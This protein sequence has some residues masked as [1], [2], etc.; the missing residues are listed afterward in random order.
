MRQDGQS[1]TIELNAF[2]SEIFDAHRALLA[3]ADPAESLTRVFEKVGRA[4]SVDR[5]Y[6]FENH[7]DEAGTVYS[8][9]RFEWAAAGVT[10]Q[11]DNPGLQ[12]I[13][14]RAAGYSR[15]LDNFLSYRPIHG[16]IDSFPESERARL[17]EQSIESLLILPVFTG[18]DLWGFVGFDDCT[19]ER[20]WTEA[21]LDLLFALT[22]TLGQLFSGQQSSDADN[23]TIAA[24][25]LVG[26][27]L[28][29]D[30]ALLSETPV[31][32]LVN[33]TRARLSVTVAVHRF[34]A[35]EHTTGEVDAGR[36][37]TALRGRLAAIRQCDDEEA[38]VCRTDVSAESF[39][40]GVEAALDV[41]MVVTEVLAVIAER[42]ERAEATANV[43]VMLRKR[44]R[45]A[46]LVITA[47]DPDGIPISPGQTFDGMAFLMIRH[48]TKKL[49]GIEN[50]RK[51][52]GMLYRLSF[53]LQGEQG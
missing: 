23:A 42:N 46:E 39:D 7:S 34:F 32:R 19:R 17:K 37:F 48:L 27:M 25:G 36:L 45:R 21:E 53:P 14:L 5:V 9:Q 26:S 44:D 11:I 8:S 15:W 38:T 28:E 33:R 30:T 43:T 40:L 29:I 6:I 31:S 13:P 18:G 3:S 10:P 50:N 4:A 52:D 35:E 51:I 41:V 47:R 22:I 49:H 16:P 24:M 20:V 1:S 12:N 2:T